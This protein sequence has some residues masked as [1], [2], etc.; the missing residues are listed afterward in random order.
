M[1]RRDACDP[2]SPRRNAVMK[3][4]Q[5]FGNGREK[6]RREWGR[7]RDRESRRE[8]A[9]QGRGE[10][11]K[12]GWREGEGKGCARREKEGEGGRKRGA[13]RGR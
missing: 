11:E 3:R 6:S 9:R 12:G 13:M 7:V 4:H 1:G 5:S 8:G 10:E 2:S